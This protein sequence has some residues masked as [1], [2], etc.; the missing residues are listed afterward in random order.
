MHSHTHGQ[1][2]PVWVY[3][4][5]QTELKESIIKEFKIHPVIAQI[6]VSRGFNSFKQIH[7]LPLCQ[8]P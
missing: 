7:D 2:E 8:A 5:T 3:P 4:T 1:E 6:L